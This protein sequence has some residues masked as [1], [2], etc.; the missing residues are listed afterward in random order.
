MQINKWEKEY[1]EDKNLISSRTDKPSTFLVELLENYQGNKQAALDLGSGKGRNSKYLSEQGFEQV[2]GVEISQT[3]IEYAKQLVNQ[4]GLESRVSFIQHSVGEPLT[5]EDKSFDLIV[6]MMVLH[7]LTPQERQVYIQ[8]VQRL[9]K[10]GGMYIFTTLCSK[11][12][13]AQDLF[14]N[15]PG[16]YPLSYII[17]QSGVIEQTFTEQ[18]LRIMFN[19]LEIVELEEYST[20]TEYGGKLYDWIYYNGIYRNPPQ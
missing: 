16:P 18:D 15:H 6:S 8:E 2:V 11:A 13:A 17:P 20:Q 9:L 7:L 19:K 1:K 4:A 5:F 12:P 3:A 10:P 14:A